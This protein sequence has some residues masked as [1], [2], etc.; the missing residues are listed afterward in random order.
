MS[1]DLYFRGY[2]SVTFTPVSAIQDIQDIPV[3]VPSASGMSVLLMPF[4]SSLKESVMT[5]V[6]KFR[7]RRGKRKWAKAH[8]GDFFRGF[9]NVPFLLFSPD[10]EVAYRLDTIKI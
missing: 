5:T 3:D 10:T 7:G 4:K 9:E 2:F 6:H 8:S 1:R